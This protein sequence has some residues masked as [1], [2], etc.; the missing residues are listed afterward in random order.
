MLDS[1]FA[2]MGLMDV[3]WNISCLHLLNQQ[4]K[5]LT[6]LHSLDSAWWVLFQHTYSW[7]LL[8]L[9]SLEA[10]KT[11]ADLS[12]PERPRLPSK[13]AHK[14]EADRHVLLALLEPCSVSA[15]PCSP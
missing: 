15:R 11:P 3:L 2:G 5:K 13:S 4:L 6:K 7:F 14:L 12:D 1:A 10:D 9:E 8:K